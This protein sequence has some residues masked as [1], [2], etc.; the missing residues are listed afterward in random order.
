[1]SVHRLPDDRW[2]AVPAVKVLIGDDVWNPVADTWHRVD[3]IHRSR[4]YIR[5]RAG[6]KVRICALDAEI[7]VRRDTDNPNGEP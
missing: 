6:T 3:D 1:M 5:F 7:V 2:V 4:G